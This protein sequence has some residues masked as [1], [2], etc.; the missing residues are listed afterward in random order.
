MKMKHI[1]R[2]LDGEKLRLNLNY[3]VTREQF[4]KG[5]EPYNV[6]DVTCVVK[7]DGS[8]VF[9]TDDGQEHKPKDFQYNYKG[10]FYKNETDIVLW[11]Y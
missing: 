9:V 2:I 6:V 10:Y 1:K 8:K 4:D 11:T 3:E 7:P 5:T